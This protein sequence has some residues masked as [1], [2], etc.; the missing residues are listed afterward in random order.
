M[1]ES[2]SPELPDEKK[3][4]DF[5]ES[6]IISIG[7]LLCYRR[8]GNTHNHLPAATPPE[9]MVEIENSFSIT[10]LT[11]AIRRTGRRH[12]SENDFTQ[13]ILVDKS[14]IQVGLFKLQIKTFFLDH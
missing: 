2:A 5:F 1:P 13:I 11:S 8:N 4:N 9:S 7:G 14:K 12:S 10:Q 6:R 3:I